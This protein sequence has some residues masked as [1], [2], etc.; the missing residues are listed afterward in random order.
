MRDLVASDWEVRNVPD[1]GTGMRSIGRSVRPRHARP[2]GE[3]GSGRSASEPDKG[4][5]PNG[6]RLSPGIR[7]AHDAATE[8]ARPPSLGDHCT[9]GFGTFFRGDSSDPKDLVPPSRLW[10][11]RIRSIAIVGR[12]LPPCRRPQRLLICR[13]S[14]FLPSHF[15]RIPANGAPCLEDPAGGTTAIIFLYSSSR[16]LGRSIHLYKTSTRRVWSAVSSMR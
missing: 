16:I 10:R 15:P 13:T 6:N 4:S 11:N 14:S 8:V 7:M 3:I 9:C 5:K 1:A 12:H 2:A